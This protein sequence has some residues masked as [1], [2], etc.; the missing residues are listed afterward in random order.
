MLK[1]L[2]ILVRA[3]LAGHDSHGVL[4]IPAYVR[5]IERWRDGRTESINCFNSALLRLLF[6]DPCDDGNAGKGK[7]LRCR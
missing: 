2:R 4:R 7:D 3:N 6:N 5:S 1:M